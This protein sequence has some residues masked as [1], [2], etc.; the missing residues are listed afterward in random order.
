MEPCWFKDK[1]QELGKEPLDCLK[2]KRMNQKI[3]DKPEDPE[4]SLFM[5]GYRLAIFE[6]A[7]YAQPFSKEQ[8][9]MIQALELRLKCAADRGMP[10]EQFQMALEVFTSRIMSDLL[11]GKDK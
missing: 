8:Q 5:D 1:H 6:I 7:S 3:M 10:L 9:D 4:L 11:K 2:C